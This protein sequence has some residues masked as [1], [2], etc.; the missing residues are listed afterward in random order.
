MGVNDS[1]FDW[2]EV[3]SGVPQGSVLGPLLFL[4]Y[5]NDIPSHVRCKIKLFADDT[6]I[7][8][9]IKTRED[10]RLLQ[11]ELEALEA[12]SD[13]WL[14]RFN[15]DKCHIMHIGHVLDTKY[16]LHKQG[17]RMALEV[18]SVERDLGVMICDDLKW[19]TQCR[20][21]AARAMSV[22]GMIK[23]TFPIIDKDS[24][25]ILYNGYVRPHLEYCVQVWAPSSV[26]D[27]ECLE[28]VQRRA[29]R[30][31]YGYRN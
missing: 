20:K 28:R 31:V 12:W 3:I 8:N 14:V 15:L 10:V 11:E 5:V 26:G 4:L 29:T 21:A 6:K 19:G 18:S 23:R 25:I 30:L 1:F 16:Y 2:E 13:K 9:I 27:V 22:L 17:L 24:F 7:W